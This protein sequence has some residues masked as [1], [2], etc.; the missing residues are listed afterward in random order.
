MGELLSVCVAMMTTMMTLVPF[1]LIPP[2][3]VVVVVDMMAL[4]SSVSAAAVSTLLS[5]FWNGGSSQVLTPATFLQWRSGWRW[6]WGWRQSESLYHFYNFCCEEVQRE[7]WT[8]LSSS[9]SSLS[10]LLFHW[11]LFYF[12]CMV[13]LIC[14]SLHPLPAPL[15]TFLLLL[16]F[17]VINVILDSPE[18]RQTKPKPCLK[19][20]WEWLLAL[21][22]VIIATVI[23]HRIMSSHCIFTIREICLNKN[24]NYNVFATSL[25]QSQW[26]NYMKGYRFIMIY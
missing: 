22:T 12:C 23:F 24:N 5:P 4:L 20:N 25:F 7:D 14:R 11:L 15:N 16:R 10:P 17:C 6:W 26:L 1:H 8:L 18:G 21:M 19:N 9:P 13:L 2:V 3:L